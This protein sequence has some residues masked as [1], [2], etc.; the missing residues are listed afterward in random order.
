MPSPKDAYAALLAERYTANTWWTRKPV[1]TAPEWDD[2]DITTARR[3]R[4]LAA[5]YD[6][7]SLHTKTA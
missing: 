4:L 5:E 6:A 2:S 7:S 1:R 3:R